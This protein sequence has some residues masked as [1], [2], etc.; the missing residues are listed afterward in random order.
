MQLATHVF[1]E[2]PSSV[3]KKTLLQ[4]RR[5]RNFCHGWDFEGTRELSVNGPRCA[6]KWE[7]RCLVLRGFL[8][9]R[10]C[11]CRTTRT[12]KRGT[13]TEGCARLCVY[14]AACIYG[15]MCAWEGEGA[16]ERWRRQERVW[17]VLY[18]CQCD[19]V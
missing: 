19:K 1:L 10:C 12:N 4:T 7:V 9:D 15:G 16:K 2:F 11:V 13:P 6:G 5:T 18:V 17:G 8:G 14:M 3:F